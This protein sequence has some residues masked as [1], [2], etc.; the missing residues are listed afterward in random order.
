[1][2]SRNGGWNMTDLKGELLSH[3][4][5][6]SEQNDF[7]Q[8]LER[9]NWLIFQDVSIRN[10][11]CMKKACAGRRTCFISCPAFAYPSSWRSS[12]ISSGRRE[13]ARFWRS[14]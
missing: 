9:G 6:E 8:F 10:F 3:L 2:V 11:C 12:G 1:M 5:S 14:A 7:F 4:L 13:I